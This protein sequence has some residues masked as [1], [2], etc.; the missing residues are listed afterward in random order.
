MHTRTT[1]ADRHALI[2][3]DGHFPSEFPG[4][5]NAT[6]FV[7]LS[8]AMGAFLSQI[9]ITFEPGGGEATFPSDENE[10]ALTMLADRSNP[11]RIHGEAPDGKARSPRR[12]TSKSGRPV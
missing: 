10:H 2:A 11:T 4:W 8:P 1:V 5:N 3:P 6:G 7:M 12:V 9:L